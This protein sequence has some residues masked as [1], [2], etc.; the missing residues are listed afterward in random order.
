MIDRFELEVQRKN[1]RPGD[2]VFD[3]G[4]NQGEWSASLLEHCADVHLYLYEPWP[5]AC[6]AAAAG[7]FAA[8]IGV[9][10]V[11]CCA[12]ALSSRRG[13]GV[14]HAYEKNPLFNTL[15]RRIDVEQQLEL[16]ERR[17]CEVPLS[18][19]DA[20]A[21]S[22][23]LRHL[24]FVKIDVEGSEG[25][26]LAGAAGL[27]RRRSIDH[28]QFEYGG[29]Y[30]AA[31]IRLVDVAVPLLERGY[32]L[33]KIDPR[34]GMQRIPDLTS[35]LEDF[36]YCNYLATAG[37]LRHQALDLKPAMFEY[38]DLFARHRVA[39]RGVVHVGAHLGEE[40]ENYKRAGVAKLV[41]IEADP[42]IYRE[43]AEKFAGHGDVITVQA[44]IS[45]RPGP[46]TFHR[47]TFSESSSLLELKEHLRLYPDI[48]PAGTLSLP[49]SSLEAVLST[50]GVDLA[51][52]NLLAVD[53]QGAE[54]RVLRSVVLRDRFDAIVTEINYREIYADCARVWD[55]DDLLEPQGFARV[56]EICPFDPT[57][58][59]ALY[60]ARAQPRRLTGRG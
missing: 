17:T 54:D 21:A 29:T 1:I 23:G 13:T 52:Y 47:A 41:F 51:E 55:L 49:A 24:N 42:Q 48:R 25:D 46:A 31:G 10:R 35:D 58:G 60:V 19:L 37:R 2:V 5:A 33:F 14:L 50:A 59:D 53:V 7:R 38:A 18:T 32:L 39:P 40:Y 22:H 28:I 27:L 30:E 20:E 44:L 6:A 45:D 9:G 26:V 34:T 12:V 11:T 43:L 56:E 15:Y 4:A 16:K 3:I 57:W 36:E 8:Q